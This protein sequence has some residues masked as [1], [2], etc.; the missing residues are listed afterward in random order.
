LVNKSITSFDQQTNDDTKQKPDAITNEPSEEGTDK[1]DHLPSSLGAAANMAFQTL[2]IGMAYQL[3]PIGALSLS[4]SE[5][6]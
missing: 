6:A 5:F 4:H 2:S 1:Y 3:S